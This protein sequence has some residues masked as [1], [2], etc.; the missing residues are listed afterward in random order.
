MD[1]S[2]R[3]RCTDT[4]TIQHTVTSELASRHR[5]RSSTRPSRCRSACFLEGGDIAAYLGASS[6]LLIRFPL[7]GAEASLCCEATRLDVGQLNG[8]SGSWVGCP[9]SRTVR[10]LRILSLFQIQAVRRP[11]R[12]LVRGRRR[13]PGSRWRGLLAQSPGSRL[14]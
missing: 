8:T 3:C 14:P 4:R 5:P 7:D 13:R 6:A 1:R 10:E 12:V 2:T 11:F 9:M